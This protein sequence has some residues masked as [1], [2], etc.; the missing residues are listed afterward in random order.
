MT[1]YLYI[2]LARK[3]VATTCNNSF[4]TNFAGKLHVFQWGIQESMVDFPA[5]LRPSCPAALLSVAQENRATKHSLLSQLLPGTP[6]IFC[7][8][9]LQ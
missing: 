6:E 9:R 2:D 4:P 7:W 3:M 1:W 8:L 5:Q